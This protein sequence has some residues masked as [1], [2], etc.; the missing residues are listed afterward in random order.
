[1]SENI[2]IGYITHFTH[3]SHNEINAAYE[4]MCDEN[5]TEVV[6]VLTRLK[7][8]IHETIRDYQT[9]IDA[10][11]NALDGSVSS[12]IHPACGSNTASASS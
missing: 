10:R 3:N 7:K 9:E 4:A 12:G 8:F 11:K 6:Q 1:M 2:K 5:E